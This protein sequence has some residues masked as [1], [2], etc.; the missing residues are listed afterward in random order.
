MRPQRSWTS[1]SKFCQIY[2]IF[3]NT[4]VSRNDI[5]YLMKE[6]AEKE[7]IMSQPRRM[8]I[9]GFH[10][11]KKKLFIT[12]LLLYYLHLGLECTEILQF[13]QYSPK[14]WL[15]SFVESAINARRQGDQ[16]PNSRVVA[17]TMKF[18]AN[19][20]YGTR[21]WIVVDTLWQ[22]IWTMKR[23][24]V[25][26]ITNFSSDLTSSLINCR[27]FNLSSEK[28]NIENQ[29]LSDS[30]LCNMIS[31]ECWSLDI[32]SLKSFPIPESMKSL[33]WIPALYI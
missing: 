28:L 27:R 23:L 11:K 22:S 24:T 17:E 29:S 20:S 13:V 12:P 14:K 4:V 8:L 6:Y 33:K 18:L 10:L 31:S 30:S 32:I 2:P 15:S 1:E 7:D 26:L 25:Q 21:S 16:N 9:L 3:K 19:S 5:G